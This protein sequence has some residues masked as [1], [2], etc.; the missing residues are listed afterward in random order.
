MLFRSITFNASGEEEDA[1]KEDLSALID[2]AKE[3]K[4]D[5]SYQYV[6]AKV[7][8]LFEAALAKAE[9]VNLNQAASQAQVDAAYDALLAKVHLLDFTGNAET[10]QSLVSIAQ[11]KV[12]SAYTK[13]SWAPFK[14]AL[15]EAEKVAKDP[16]ALQAE[17][18]AAHDTLQEKMNALVKITVNKDKLA[19]LVA[20]AAKYEAE[21][22][23]YTEDTAAAFTAALEGARDVLAN[24]EVQ[25][26]VNAAYS[27][28]LS[29]IFGLRETPNK[30]KLE[31]LL[32]K[33]EAMDL[34][35]YSA[36]TAGAVKAAYA[37]AMAVFKD[38]NADQKEVDAAVAEL[39]KAIAA[40][41]G[42]VSGE[43]DETA[44]SEDKV[45]SD[46][47]GNKTTKGKTNKVAGNTAAKTGDA[48]N[49]F[50]LAGLVL[51][52]GIVLIEMRKRKAA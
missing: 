22:A 38:E 24:A 34:S 43:K 21:I 36:K 16:N 35:A 50:A 20:D 5:P 45:A 4:E 10:L 29:A 37:K 40:A 7:K 52:S 13:E 25:A 42:S 39:E 19:K 6:V 14:A 47:A 46:N 12:E 30:D 15:T 11:G 2:Y 23:K 51:L 18:D 28:L 48:A 27:S 44:K 49:P 33:V 8:E 41:S 9:E 26:E 32:G 17:L 3:A 31:N 1:D